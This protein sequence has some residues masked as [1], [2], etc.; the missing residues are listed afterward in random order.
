MK[1]RTVALLLIVTV[2]LLEDVVHGI[3]WFVDHHPACMVWFLV[4]ALWT[5]VLVGGILFAECRHKKRQKAKPENPE[6]QHG[7]GC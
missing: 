5:C 7:N 2:A 6:R 1:F 3:G 4:W